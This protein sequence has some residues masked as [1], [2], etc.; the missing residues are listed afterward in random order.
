MRLN[1]EEAIPHFKKAIDLGARSV[2]YYYEL[3]LSYVFLNQCDQ[4]LPW[5]DQALELDPDSQ[6][7]KEG[8]K[9]CEGQ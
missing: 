9:L 2:E 4:A 8:L 7:A 6:P 3:G 5:L 1:W